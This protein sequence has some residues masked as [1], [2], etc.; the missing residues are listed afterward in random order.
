MR[1]VSKAEPRQSDNGVGSANQSNPSQG[2]LTDYQA[3]EEKLRKKLLKQFQ[4]HLEDYDNGT[5]YETGVD[6]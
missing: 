6:Y 4:D 5:E 2:A 1:R 3:Y